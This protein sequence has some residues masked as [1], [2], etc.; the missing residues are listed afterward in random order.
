M[1]ESYL[2]ISDSVTYSFEIKKSTFI[3]H[4]KNV[5]SEDE[6]KAFIKEMKDKY[7]D[8][9]HL[10]Y[11]YICD[12][13]G[14]NFKYSDGGEPQG[15]AGVPMIEVLRN[16]NLYMVIAVVIRYFGGIKL[17]T[18]GLARAYSGAVKECVESANIVINKTVAVAKINVDYATYPKLQNFLFN[19]KPIIISSD[20]NDV[21]SVKIGIVLE[22]EFS[23]KT[24]ENK[25]LDFFKGT[26]SFEIL[27]ETYYP[28]KL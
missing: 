14:Y 3:C 21:V 4:L 20:F 8:C 5:E 23:I 25:F 13:K 16:K 2:T 10:C 6:C 9:R 22:D 1:K 12:E 15:T 27:G 17:G 7:T 26:L 11:A 18:G 19:E 28:I 24:F